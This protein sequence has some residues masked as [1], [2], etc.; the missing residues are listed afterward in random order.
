MLHIFGIQNSATIIKCWSYNQTVPERNIVL[1]TNP[2][3]VLIH[4]KVKGCILATAAIPFVTFALIVTSSIPYFR[5]SIQWNSLITCT[6]TNTVL[7][8]GIFSSNDRICCCL[9]RSFSL[10]RKAYIQMLE[11]MNILDFAVD[12]VP[13]CRWTLPGK[14]GQRN[15][16]QMVQEEI[17]Q[18]RQ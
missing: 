4:F 3:R 18:L 5:E 16:Q 2:V 9:A 1:S 15:L 6:D 12:V 10:S 8:D 14:D 17:Q 13:C 7:T 11:S